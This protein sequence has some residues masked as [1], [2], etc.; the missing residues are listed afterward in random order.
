M[1]KTTNKSSP[2]VRARAVRLALGTEFQ[3]GSRWQA[4]VSIAAK[5]SCSAQMLN[6]WLKQ[7]E[8]HSGKR[9]GVLTEPA[10]DHVPGRGV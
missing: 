1:R 4:I 7:A 6:D 2:G 3:H 9:A 10:E 8:G 5:I